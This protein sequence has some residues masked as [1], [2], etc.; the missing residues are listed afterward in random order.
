[1]AETA[2]VHH[3]ISSPFRVRGTYGGQK[4]GFLHL[5]KTSKSIQEA[6]LSWRT[7]RKHGGLS[8]F[9]AGSMA[10]GRDGEFSKAFSPS[11]KWITADPTACR[12]LARC[13]RGLGNLVP[14]VKLCQT[15]S[16]FFFPLR[17]SDL[18]LIG[19][20]F[21]TCVSKEFFHSPCLGS[22]FQNNISVN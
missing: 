2:N 6:V 10:V 21:S 8:H 19:I 15:V 22:G 13:P 18:S 9:S 7:W 4:G 16:T 20:F 11:C 3:Y 12:A 14:E 5:S 1:M 17:L